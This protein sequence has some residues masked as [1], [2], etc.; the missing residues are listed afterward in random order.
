MGS[1]GGG[2]LGEDKCLKKKRGK[3]GVN[4]GKPSIQSST[5]SGI[6]T[7]SGCQVSASS[8]GGAV[9]G[10]TKTQSHHSSGYSSAYS[11]SNYTSTGRHR[12]STCS[13]GKVVN[14]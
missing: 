6:T 1:L 4:R 7:S 8:N 3:K 11:N 13:T 5:R 9:K 10:T 2:S 12:A 14:E